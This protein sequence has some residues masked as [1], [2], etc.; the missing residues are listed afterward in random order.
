MP[1]IPKKTSDKSTSKISEEI[2]KATNELNTVIQPIEQYDSTKD[3][4]ELIA[5]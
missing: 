1:E 3:I 5:N 4:L 2:T